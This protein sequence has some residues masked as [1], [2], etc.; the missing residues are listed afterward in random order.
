M[1]GRR[2]PAFVAVSTNPAI[3][4]VA[5]IEGAP[6]GVVARR[7]VAR[8][9]GRQ[10]VHAACVAA[11]L[12]AETA[13]VTTAGGRSGDRSS[14]CSPPSRSRSPSPVAASTRGTYT[15]VGDAAAIWSRS[16]SPAAT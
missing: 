12:G 3:D 10:G 9:A 2:R 8:D 6:S 7:R 13:I 4:R 5:R 15:L 16:T 14:R 1:D 11:E